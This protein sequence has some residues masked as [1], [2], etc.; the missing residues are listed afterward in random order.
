[1]TKV[2]SSRTRPARSAR[3]PRSGIEVPY[4]ANYRFG[5]GH[6]G[7]VRR[8]SRG[9]GSDPPSVR[10]QRTR[11]PAREGLDARGPV[12]RYR[13]RDGSDLPR[14]ARQARG[15]PD[16]APS[17]ARRARRLR[18]CAPRRPQGL[19]G[20]RGPR[21]GPRCW[22]PPL[23]SAA[24]A[25]GSPALVGGPPRLAPTAAACRAGLSLGWMTV[26]RAVGVA[27]GLD[28]LPTAA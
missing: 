4:P 28:G 11:R 8:A 17:T 21:A 26:E 6:F 18:R 20:R 7:L 5:F 9:S 13:S 16:H 25:A 24:V 12:G 1:M 2:H 3:R 23:G 14:G 27:A 19:G 10:A 22:G 15:S